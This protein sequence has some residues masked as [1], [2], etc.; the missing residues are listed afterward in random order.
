MT[1]KRNFENKRK[2]ESE[3]G[4]NVRDCDTE[5]EIARGAR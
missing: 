1:R 2:I 3:K 4:K 5:E